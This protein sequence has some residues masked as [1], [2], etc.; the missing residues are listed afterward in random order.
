MGYLA[1]GRSA[2]GCG[3]LVAPEV[4]GRTRPLVMVITALL[5][6][7]LFGN[8]Y[9]EVVWIPRL[10]VHPRA[11]TLVE[12]FAP[13][14]PVYYYLP[15]SPMAVAL[16]GFLRLRFGALVPA[17]IRRSWTGAVSA[18]V[19]ALAGKVFLIVE[20][21]PV[22]RDPAAAAH[23]VHDRA[24]LWASC[25]GAVIVAVAIA[26]VL[27]KV[28]RGCAELGRD[29]AGCCD[30]AVPI[31]AS[32]AP[33]PTRSGSSAAPAGQQKAGTASSDIR[34]PQARSA[35]RPES[36]P[37]PRAEHVITVSNTDLKLFPRPYLDDLAELYDDFIGVMDNGDNPRAAGCSNTWPAAAGLSTSDAATAGTPG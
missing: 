20:V 9:E 21:N 24:L 4:V 19:V 11:G 17:R 36:S 23:L 34:C 26:A 10:I 22:F 30:P 15:W 37:S 35:R 5:G 12:S 27:L 13:G 3:T 7:W 31:M 16:A 14:S 1:G 29:R 18:L 2:T 8:L 32:T 28:P 25:N 33:V 6:M